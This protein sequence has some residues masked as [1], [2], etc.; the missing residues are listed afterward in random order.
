MLQRHKNK[1][2]ITNYRSGIFLLHRKSINCVTNA[3]FCKQCLEQT[4]LVAEAITSNVFQKSFFDIK[5]NQG[6]ALKEWRGH[7][8]ESVNGLFSLLCTMP[9]TS[10]LHR[11][12]WKA[13]SH[14]TVEHFQLLSPVFCLLC[15]FSSMK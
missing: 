9:K 4:S 13:A 3:V 5:R 12:H 10:I 14:E 15:I 1:M 11:N 2:L 7:K 8:S 6:C